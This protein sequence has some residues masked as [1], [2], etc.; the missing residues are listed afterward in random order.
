MSC[1]SIGWWSIMI[2]PDD[3]CDHIMHICRQ[4]R[5][6]CVMVSMSTVVHVRSWMW[7]MRR[8]AEDV[9]QIIRP[10]WH[11]QITRCQLLQVEIEIV[12]GGA[13]D[14]IT[15]HR[16]T[17]GRVSSLQGCDCRQAHA[18]QATRRQAVDHVS[19]WRCH[20]CAAYWKLLPGMSACW[21]CL[22]SVR[23]DASRRGARPQ[24]IVCMCDRRASLWAA[25]A[26]C[27]V[28]GYGCRVSTMHSST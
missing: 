15:K 27:L 24:R 9:E 25:A 21:V 4:L 26:G 19:C 13:D 14:W 2:I 22:C 6:Q 12:T 8:A 17:R 20:G 3:G 18:R 7:S 28:D 23:P 1:R 10:V 16:D 11:V 5:Q